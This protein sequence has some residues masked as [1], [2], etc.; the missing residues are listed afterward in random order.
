MSNRSIIP[1]NLTGTALNSKPA[2]ISIN[3]IDNLQTN[4]NIESKCFICLDSVNCYYKFVCGCHNYFHPHC[5]KSKSIDKCFICGQNIN[6]QIIEFDIYDLAI[7][8]KI[9]NNIAWSLKE[10]FISL[11]NFLPNNIV[12]CLYKISYHSFYIFICHPCIYLNILYN[13]IKMCLTIGI[14]FISNLFTFQ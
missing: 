12:L 3:S 8:E 6:I 4:S 11:S 5:L 2:N 1:V 9:I 10:V 14:K 13:I 7:S